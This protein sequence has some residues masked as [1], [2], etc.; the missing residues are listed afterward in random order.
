MENGNIHQFAQAAFDDETFR[1]LDVF[2]I[3]AAEGGAEVTHAID[4]LI[5]VFGV[6]LEIDGID[7]G[8][9]LEQHRLAFHDRLGGERAE[10]AETEDGRAVGDDRHHVAARGVVVSGRRIFGDGFH[11]HGHSRR[12]GKRQIPLSRHRLGRGDFQ[13]PRSA[14]RVEIQGF[15]IRNRC[16]CA[17]GFR[18]VG[19]GLSVLSCR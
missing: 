1:R 16:S 14:F 7:I 4:E 3:N 8:E 9:A 17:G 19:H 5:G 12:I 6:D 13:F 11:R 15:L 18:R 2:Q 10:I